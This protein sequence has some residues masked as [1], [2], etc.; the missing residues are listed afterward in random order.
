MSKT[1]AFD[2]DGTLIDF[3]DNPREEII[4]KL[5]Q[6]A[7]NG[8]IVYVWSG[9]GIDYAQRVV[10]RLHLDRYV[11]AVIAKQRYPTLPDI[12]YDDMVIKLGKRNIHV[13]PFEHEERW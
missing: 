5:R 13:G 8:D 4:A 7:I 1:V 2:V 10:S 11:D 9:G 3:D 12:T 6:H